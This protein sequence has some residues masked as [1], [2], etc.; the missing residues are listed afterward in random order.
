MPP[1][2]CV[3]TVR[4]SNC[5][6]PFTATAKLPPWTSSPGP[7]AM[8]MTRFRQLASR[9]TSALKGFKPAASFTGINK[10]RVA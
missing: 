10:Y 6:R 1:Q 7:R 5:F 2:H 9:R 4:V 3:P 8:L